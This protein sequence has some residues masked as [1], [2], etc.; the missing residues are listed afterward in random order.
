MILR[1]LSKQGKFYFSVLQQH[2][3]MY[4]VLNQ[5]HLMCA[6]YVN[7]YDALPEIGHACGHNLIAEA[8]VA[9]GLGV[10]A[11][12][13]ATGSS[14]GITVLGTPAEEGGGGKILPIERVLLMTLMLL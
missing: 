13:E 12:L 14:G 9:V 7:N 11:Y 5:V 3:T 10:K 4:V 2:L 1:M 8:G 6:L